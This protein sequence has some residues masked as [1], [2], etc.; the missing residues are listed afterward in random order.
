M[1]WPIAA[2]NLPVTCHVTCKNAE[3]VTPVSTQHS[4]GAWDASYENHGDDYKDFQQ[5]DQLEKCCGFTLMGLKAETSWQRLKMDASDESRWQRGSWGT[6]G[7]AE[8]A[9]RPAWHTQAALGVC[10][11]TQRESVSMYWAAGGKWASS[12]AASLPPP[13]PCLYRILV[14]SPL[15]ISFLLALSPSNAIIAH[16]CVAA[17]R[18][19]ATFSWAPRCV[20]VFTTH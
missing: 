19:A 12:S 6:A 16:S 2:L 11:S 18:W 10:V 15:I 20:L 7:R 13:L 5:I 8:R 14:P 4:E 17:L 3:A 1:T 9:V